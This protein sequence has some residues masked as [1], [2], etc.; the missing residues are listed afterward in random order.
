MSKYSSTSRMRYNATSFHSE[1]EDSSSRRIAC[2]LLNGDDSTQAELLPTFV[3]GKKRR[4]SESFL[5]RVFALRKYYIVLLLLA[6]SSSIRSLL[7]SL[8]RPSRVTPVPEVHWPLPSVVLKE[9]L[10]DLVS[11]YRP[12]PNFDSE[13]GWPRVSYF[14]EIPSVDD[15][16]WPPLPDDE[17]FAKS[18]KEP[19]IA[20][21][22]PGLATDVYDT[23]KLSNFIVSNQRQELKANELIF[24]LSD[25]NTVLQQTSELRITGDAWCSD[26][27]KSLQDFHSNLVIVCVGERITAGRARNVLSRVATSDVLAF[28]DT[29]DEEEPERNRVIQQTFAC[30]PQLKLLLHSN[31]GT[32]HGWHG[33]IRYHPFAE[34]T[35]Q[36]SAITAT[37][38]EPSTGAG[39]GT[40][41]SKN[42]NS[43]GNN[44]TDVVVSTA[45]V[46]PDEQPGVEVIRGLELRRIL[47]E[48]QDILKFGI[49]TVGGMRPGHLVVHRS[50]IKWVRSS[51]IYKGQD[52][53]WARDIIYMYGRRDEAAMFL[54]RPLST[55]Y[56]SSHSYMLNVK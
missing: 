42:T 3:K 1:E 7:L 49:R 5:Q 34:L 12:K 32:G 44:S 37:A 15:P 23:S 41:S 4:R 48:T 8:R 29:D 52:T 14:E 36:V 46:C 56:Q 10:P 19:T 40:D 43:S 39:D 33:K 30:H 28:I 50:V 2:H 45:E 51:S 54:N 13:S 6:A 26:V 11:L 20:T 22:V 17:Q 25:V 35:E 21:C 24:V 27:Y 55:Y 16:L 38:V 47:D 18:N 31:Y 53:L 9:T